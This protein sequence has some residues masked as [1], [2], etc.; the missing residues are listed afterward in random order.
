MMTD[1]LS[2]K[3]ESLLKKGFYLAITF[4]IASLIYWLLPESCPEAA[5]R[6]AFVF[7]AAAILWAFEVLPLYVTS[8]LIV[9]LLS[10]SLGKPGGVM[11]MGFSGY[12]LFLLP[13]S[14]PV[15]MLF[16]GG[17]MLAQALK[18]YGV[19]RYITQAVISRFGTKPIAVLFGILTSSAVLSMWISNT[20]ATAIVL[21]IVLPSIEGLDIKGSFKK[22]LLL[23]IP[24][25]ANVGGIATPIGSPPNAIA[26]GFLSEY[27][28]NIDFFGWMTICIPLM[29]VIL[30]ITGLVLYLF[31]PAKDTAIHLLRD[32]KT[33]LDSKGKLVLVIAGVTIALFLLFPL[34]RIPEPLVALFC[35]T[36]L[37]VTGLLNEEDL[38]SIAWD[39]LILMWGG[40]ALGLAVAKTGLASWFVTLPIFAQHGPLLILTFCI[41]AVFF[42]MFISNTATVALLLP[43]AL[44]IEGENKIALAITITLVSNLAMVFPISTPPNAIA[45]SSHL[46]KTKDMVK[47]GLT[48]SLISVILILVGYEVIIPI[49]L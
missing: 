16:F 42:S 37:L 49:L 8:L 5:R 10:F 21:G 39:I 9:V 43:V 11:N 4:L 35:V 15:I 38:K 6:T 18:K 34:H 17:F 32:G 13:F 19:D 31:F 23:A 36:M 40:L 1:D 2:T 28:Y 47:A 7:V 22:A 33:F 20:V 26:L 24:Y 30:V 41:A 12:T 44:G 29:L 48:I 46:F 45:Y 25:G 27:G 14:S 3:N